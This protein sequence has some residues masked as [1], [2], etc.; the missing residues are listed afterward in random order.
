VSIDYDASRNLHTLQGAQAALAVLFSDWKPTS[1]LDIGCGRGTWMRAA[2]DQGVGEVAGVDGVV[3]SDDQLFVPAKLVQQCDLTQPWSLGKRFD[4][5]LCLEVAEHLD[6]CFAE[7]LIL[8]LARQADV[9]VFSAACPGQLGQHH[10]NCQWPAYWQRIFN[11]CGF[12]CSDAI[13][14]RIWDD[15][16]IEPWYHQNIFMANRDPRSAGQESRI[17]PVVHPEMR[18]YLAKS[19]VGT[20]QL[21]RDQQPRQTKNAA[22]PLWRGIAAPFK[23]IAS[24]MVRRKLGSNAASFQ[25]PEDHM[26]GGNLGAPIDRAA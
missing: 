1:V 7:G 6:E 11:N 3:L 16:R 10:V 20:E 4:A 21:T 13:R 19:V 9:V 17:K 5:A 12:S 26:A 2:I 22:L 23:A 25:E 18:R 14:W 24:R 15:A 8:S